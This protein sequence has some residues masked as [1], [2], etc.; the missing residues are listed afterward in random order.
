MIYT[1]MA[2]HSTDMVTI[3]TTD[4]SAISTYASMAY[5]ASDT[6]VIY[7]THT[8]IATDMSVIPAHAAMVHSA[9]RAITT[10]MTVVHST[11]NTVIG[12]S[13]VTTATTTPT[14][15][16]TSATAVISYS[17][18]SLSFRHILNFFMNNYYI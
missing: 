8:A 7:T 6:A 17:F 5:P 18:F 11:T 9:S 12:S 1:P 10:D 2:T 3:D 14:G 13:S 4:V 15:T 16:A